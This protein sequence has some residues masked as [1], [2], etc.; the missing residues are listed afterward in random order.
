MFGRKTW[1]RKISAVLRSLNKAWENVSTRNLSTNCLGLFRCRMETADGTLIGRGWHQGQFLLLLL[2]ILLLYPGGRGEMKSKSESKK[3]GAPDQ[4]FKV[5]GLASEE[6]PGRPGNGWWGL[7][8]LDSG[9]ADSV[10][11]GRVRRSVCQ[12]FG[13]CPLFQAVCQRVIRLQFQP[14]QPDECEPLSLHTQE[15]EVHRQLRLKS[16]NHNEYY[17][18]LNRRRSGN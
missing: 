4:R 12:N 17:L 15:R 7:S 18:Q 6:P 16:P 13:P 2:I 1:G 8:G 5:S 3:G 11:Q 14:Q 10:V 9:S